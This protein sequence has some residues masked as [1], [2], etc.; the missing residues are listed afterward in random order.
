MEVL[1][2]IQIVKIEMIHLVL[3]IFYFVDIYYFLYFVKQVFYF[4]MI[5]KVFLNDSNSLIY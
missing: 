1:K 5:V 3:F 4:G 2:F